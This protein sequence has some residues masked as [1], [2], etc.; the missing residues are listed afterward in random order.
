LE[1]SFFCIIYCITT[2]KGTPSSLCEL[3]K[4]TERWFKFIYF[5]RIVKHRKV[6]LLLLDT[7]KKTLGTQQ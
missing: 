7:N 5:T 1:I 6:V 3:G 2:T 4:L